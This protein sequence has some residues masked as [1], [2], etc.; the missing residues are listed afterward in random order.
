MLTMKRSL[1]YIGKWGKKQLAKQYV[2]NNPFF[3]FGFKKSMHV[4][5]KEGLLAVIAL[6]E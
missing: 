1:Q 5:L 4:D 6:G 2:L 3:G